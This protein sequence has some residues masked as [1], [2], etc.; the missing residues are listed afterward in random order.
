MDDQNIYVL[1][2]QNQGQEVTPNESS[3]RVCSDDRGQVYMVLNA[4]QVKSS[5]Y[6]SL[7]IGD[8]TQTEVTKREVKDAKRRRVWITISILLT[9]L[10]VFMLIAI[11]IGA[12]GLRGSI[13][14][15]ETRNCTYLMAE[16][17]AL[18]SLLI[19]M[20]IETQQNV[21]L[22]DDRLSSS[23]SELSSS[24]ESAFSSIHQL[25]FTSLSQLSETADQISTSVSSLSSSVSR[26]QSSAT[27][28][29][30]A[31]RS[32]K[33]T[34][35]RTLSSSV[36]SLSTSDI[37]SLSTSASELSTSISS[38]CTCQRGPPN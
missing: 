26:I 10:A 12:L 8:T 21:S 36:A 5:E 17:S 19:Q 25:S 33:I 32:L 3:E 27:E 11:A 29:F 23:A 1:D 37:Y 16:I 20:S 15:K 6:E 38:S 30:N 34:N 28:N 7:Q 4:A 24:A 14:S 22:L 13:T 9:G 2:D 18:K 35:I 31:I